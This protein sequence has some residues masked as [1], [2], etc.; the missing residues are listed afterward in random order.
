M[1]INISIIL[2]TKCLIPYVF[3]NFNLNGNVNFNILKPLKL[4]LKLPLLFLL[5]YKFVGQYT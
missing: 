3:L 5:A 2:L 1:A 4:L